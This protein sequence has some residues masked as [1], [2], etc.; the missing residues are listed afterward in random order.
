MSGQPLQNPTDASKFRQNYL[1][2]L[3]LMANIDDTNLQANKI[4]KKTGQTPTQPTDSRTTAE[5]LAD[6]ERLKIDVRSALSQIADGE[7]SNAIVQELDPYELTFLAQHID[8]I[9]KEIKPKYKYG[10]TAD[11]FVPFLIA[12]IDKANTTN[13]VSFGLQQSAGRHLI[14]SVE[15]ILNDM[16][17]PAMIQQLRQDLAGSSNLMSVG[18]QNAIRRDLEELQRVIPSRDDLT[19]IAQIQDTITRRAIQEEL[20]DALQVLPTNQQLIALLRDL[21]IALA[22]RDADRSERIGLQ[23]HQLLN[24]EPATS[25]QVRNIQQQIEDARIQNAGLHRQTQSI[26]DMN[27]ADIK[28]YIKHQL[29]VMGISNR[30]ASASDRD[31]IVEAV[32]GAIQEQGAETTDDINEIIRQAVEHIK[33]TPEEAGVAQ[34][35]PIT[36]RQLE[37][38]SQYRALDSPALSTNPKISD[39]ITSRLKYIQPPI[40]KADFCREISGKP[41]PTAKSDLQKIAKE[42]NRRLRILGYG[43]EN[44]A[45]VGEGIGRIKGKGVYRNK[46]VKSTDYSKGIMPVNK[47]VPFGRFHIDNHKLGNDIV[48]IKRGTGCNVSGFPVERVSKELAGVLRTIV[49]GGQPQFHQLEKLSPDEKAYL[50]KLAKHSNIIDRLSIPTPN[51]DDDDKDIN[52]FEIMKGELLN[53]N[54]S[55]DLIKKFKILIMKMVKKE[56]LPKSQAKD[57]LMDLASLGY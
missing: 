34:A 6:V 13:E 49:G 29:N 16:V 2:N 19:G 7:Q 12:Y 28:R 30:Q 8:E 35:Q 56:L 48:S 42:L 17:N 36:Q 51:K 37:I 20:N 15:Q 33:S 50:H 55:A 5:K 31:S 57:I 46:I 11:I 10:I 39:Y 40:S 27:Q 24:V 1:A 3:A 9:V 47:Y 38:Q 41:Y 53:G 54:D 18:L 4:Y 32:L 52:Q 44:P 45:G 26:L 21:E 23:L 14:M 25:E 43:T 22:R